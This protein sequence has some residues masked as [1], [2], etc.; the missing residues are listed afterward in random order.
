M[1]ILK[2][3]K[4]NVKQNIHSY[5]VKYKVKLFNYAIR[6]RSSHQQGKWFANEENKRKN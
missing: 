6:K 1:F 4:M 5:N 3:E 2:L